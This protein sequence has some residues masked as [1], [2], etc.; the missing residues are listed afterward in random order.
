V[1]EE[2]TLNPQYGDILSPASTPPVKVT[3]HGAASFRVRS[4]GGKALVLG[5][6]APGSGHVKGTVTVFARA[7]GKTGA[8]RKVATDRLAT[9]Q[10]NFAISAPLAAGTW[11]VKVKF[12][13]P[14]QGVVAATSRTVRVTIG[15]KP[16]SSV[17]LS[18]LKTRKGGFT[19]SATASPSGGSGAKIELLRLNAT[20]G[21][22]A[23][24]TVSG[25][26]SLGSGKTKAPFH[27]RVNPGT[28]VLQLEYTR[29]GQAPSFSA[30]RTVTIH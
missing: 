21:A 6:V 12:Q 17:S 7:V 2:A 13:D 8:F 14:K 16:A 15:P 20:P 1:I 27:D 25:S 22:P 10:G 29:P 19:A 26:A 28:W 18:S 4:Q 5:T 24:F 30:P 23:R 9:S 11:D 3:V